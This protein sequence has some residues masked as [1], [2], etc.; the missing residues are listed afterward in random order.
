MLQTPS[1][2]LEALGSTVN[3]P[4]ACSRQPRACSGSNVT[5]GEHTIQYELCDALK[6]SE[7]NSYSSL[8]LAGVIQEQ[9]AATDQLASPDI[10]VEGAR[11]KPWLE[12]VPG[13][14][15]SSSLPHGWSVRI[16]AVNLTERCD[17]AG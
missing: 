16:A 15:R 7:R 12:Q 10:R 1:A 6:M 14:R 9:S 8:N 4:R 2:H 5:M 11:I 13:R 3:L 17:L